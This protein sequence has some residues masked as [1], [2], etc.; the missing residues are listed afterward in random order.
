MPGSYKIVLMD[1]DDVVIWTKDKVKPADGGGG[2]IVD[3]DY[4]Y[5]GYSARFSENI[6]TTGL[7]D[8]LAQILDLQY[9]GPA[10]SLSGSGSTTIREKGTSVASTSL[11]ATV[12]KR[13]DPIAAVRFYQGA[14]LIDTNTGTIPTG[15]VEAHTYSTPF[16]DTISFSAQA[17][18]NGATGGPTTV[19][20]GVT[21]T[22]V[23]P[24]YH[25]AGAA[26]LSASGVG[27]LTK[28]LIVS[29]A[30]VTKTITVNGSQKMFFAYPASYGALTS[31]LDV[32]N[33]DVFP[34]WTLR[35]ENITGLDGAAVSYR[36]YEFNN[37]AVAGDYFFSFRR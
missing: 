23:Y 11:T 20:A 27:A 12:T 16:T 8:T 14:T 17:D 32:N 13:S 34:D 31:I 19:T 6:L 7:S 10:I 30:T 24:Y 37:T 36:I 1:A 33:F 2:G 15:G 22:F 21:F 4:V 35:T 9:T 28:T 3:S 29:T 18:D 25:G 5:E 26:A